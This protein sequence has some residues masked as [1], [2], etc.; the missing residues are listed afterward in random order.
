MII[1]G[2]LR[3]V[4]DP[5]KK[6][7]VYGFR[8]PDK[9][10]DEGLWVGYEEPETAAAKSIYAKSKGLGGVAIL[11]LGLDDSR[12]ICDGRKFPITTAAKLNL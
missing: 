9:K 6:M 12:G 7:G 1:L 2:T 8:L 3:R 4:T 11:D 5:E 10:I